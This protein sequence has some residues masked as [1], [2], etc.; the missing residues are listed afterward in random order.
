MIDSHCHLA[1]KKFASDL[2]AVL[3]RAASVG[4][5]RCVT[6]ADTIEEGEKCL[7]IAAKYDQLFCTIGVHPH[8][9]KQWTVNSGQKLREMIESSSK[10]VAVGECG[11]DYHYMNSPK[12]DQ[13]RAFKDQITIAQELDLPLVVHNRDSIEDMHAILSDLN[14]KSM[15]LH[16]CTEK[17]ED[18]SSLVDR[19][20]LLGFTGIATYAKSD[21][22][23]HTIK[24]CP[25]DQMMI[26]TDAPY[27]A[28]EGARGKRC[29]PAFVVEVA[30]LVA[31][32]KGVSLEEIDQITTKNAEAFYSLV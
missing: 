28:P 7:E 2:D 1:D 20:Y 5:D 9:S 25:L 16:C 14:P 19:G 4:V 21:D 23:R 26:E 10:V 13:I 27:L 12:E 18:V 17:W 11:L 22:I 6:I 3:K 31:E 24:H 30:K 15:V 8:V 32:I 29:E